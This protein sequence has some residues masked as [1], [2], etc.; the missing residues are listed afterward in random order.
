MLATFL[1]GLFTT[2]LKVG[3]AVASPFIAKNVVSPSK[4]K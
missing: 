1:C 3:I 2:G 4:G